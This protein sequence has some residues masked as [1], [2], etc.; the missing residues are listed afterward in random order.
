VASYDGT[1]WSPLS[2]GINGIFVNSFATLTN[3]L[4]IAG[5]FNNAS[6][7][8]TNNIASWN[9]SGFFALGQGVDTT[10]WALAAD[11]GSVY[12]GGEFTTAGGIT[13]SHIA[14][15]TPE[16]TYVLSSSVRDI[17]IYPNPASNYV[18]IKDDLAHQE[19]KEISVISSL[20]V[21]M[22]S[23]RSMKN[24]TFLPLEE[25]PSGIYFIR[26]TDQSQN[27]VIKKLVIR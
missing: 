27:S 24:E 6:G 17:R 15:W 20:G 12:V 18:V 23:V 26:I 9:G 2:S 14:K 7:T 21:V 8:T 11:T 10:V 3:T 13:V 4:Y 1:G 16:P 5:D 22:M 19:V 25:I